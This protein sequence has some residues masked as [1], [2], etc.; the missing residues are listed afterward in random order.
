[1][2]WIIGVVG[3][4]KN[5]IKEKIVSILPEPI[6]EFEENDLIIKSGGN[7]KSC[8]YPQPDNE[9]HKLLRCGNPFSFQLQIHLREGSQLLMVKVKSQNNHTNTNLHPRFHLDFLFLPKGP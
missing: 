1:M 3:T 6:V 9:V 7:R 5:K 2:S 8:F 4:E